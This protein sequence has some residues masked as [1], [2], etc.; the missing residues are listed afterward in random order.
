MAEQH[1]SVEEPSGFLH[2]DVDS[3]Q[4]PE[5][6]YG[7]RTGVAR[8]RAD[9]GDPLIAPR[10]RRLE[11]LSDQLHGDVLE[12]ERR[13]VMQ[14]Q[15]PV[16]RA[17]L[18]QRAARGVPEPCIGA[19]DDVA[20]LLLAERVADKGA[21]HS[22]GDRLVGLAREPGD[23]LGAECRP[24]LGHIKAAVAGEPGQHRLFEIQNRGGAPR[25]DIVHWLGLPSVRP[26]QAIDLSRPCRNQALARRR[27]RRTSA[28]A[29]P[30]QITAIENQVIA[31]CR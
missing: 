10:E 27:A 30:A 2:E 18:R 16:V 3:L 22:L 26:R 4:T 14:L 23:R 8:G 25:A 13:P 12:G 9:N 20:E 21:H 17:D 15:H 29:N 24:C 19:G 28:T 31:Y 6:L 11:Q 7:G 1:R 5:R